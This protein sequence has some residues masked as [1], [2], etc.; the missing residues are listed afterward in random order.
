MACRWRK[1][2][3]AFARNTATTAISK[4]SSI[5]SQPT[6]NRHTLSLM[7]WVSKRV[8]NTISERLSSRDSPSRRNAS[9]TPRGLSLP[10]ISSTRLNLKN[11][12]SNCNPIV[13]RSSVNCPCITKRWD[14]FS[15]RI[16]ASAPSTCF[17]ISSEANGGAFAN[18]TQ[19][20]LCA[21]ITAE[22]KELVRI[23]TSEKVSISAQEKETVLLSRLSEL[24]S[25][26]VALSGGADSAY[27]AWAAHRALGSRALSVTALSPSYSAHDRT[28]VKEFVGKYGVRHEFIETHEMDNPAYRANASDRRRPAQSGDSASVAARRTA[29]LGSPSLRVP[30]FAPSLRHRSDYRAPRAGG[31]WRSRS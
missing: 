6:T 26:L 11:F 2:G 17:W 10:A 19:D 16:R 1:A 24:P 23:R 13:N 7:L 27:L 22:M 28:V 5:L 14:I 20:A 4:P 29:D 21:I 15:K 25:L 12:S 9:S 31:T 8:F 18:A 3:T 30:R